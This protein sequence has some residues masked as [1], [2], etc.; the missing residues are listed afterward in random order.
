MLLK[1]TAS[2]QATNIGLPP[3]PFVLLLSTRIAQW[4][5]K[6]WRPSLMSLKPSK[7]ST[8]KA[9]LHVART[10]QTF[11]DFQTVRPSTED[12]PTSLFHEQALFSASLL[13]SHMVCLA[14]RWYCDP[15][16]HHPLQLSPLITPSNPSQLLISLK[17]ELQPTHLPRATQQSLSALPKMQRIDHKGYKF[18]QNCKWRFLQIQAM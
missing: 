9:C 5:G 6:D 13:G 10:C 11:R 16:S 3:P 18:A 1:T 14:F 12:R 15:D 8:C 17:L 4:I 2:T 7:P